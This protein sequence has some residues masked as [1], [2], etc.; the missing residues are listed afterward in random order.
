MPIDGTAGARLCA[1]LL[2][3]LA[4]Q[5]AAARSDGPVLSVRIGNLDVLQAGQPAAIDVWVQ[6][7]AGSPLPLLLT[8]STEGD[9]VSV[10]RGRML[11][12]DA[13]ASPEGL[14]F[15]VPLM[16]RTEGT[17]ILRVLVESYACDKVCR[18]VRASA[19]RTLRARPSA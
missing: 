3:A 17:A 18:P 16:V 2:V 9:A 6:I 11:G 14:L 5:P 19:T 7:P 13:Q 1:V 12:S 4:C 15:R 10:V 8:P